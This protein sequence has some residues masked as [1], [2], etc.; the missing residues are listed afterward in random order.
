V[1]VEVK[2]PVVVVVAL[3]EEIPVVEKIA[4]LDNPHQ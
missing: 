2:L 4:M 3:A 1:G